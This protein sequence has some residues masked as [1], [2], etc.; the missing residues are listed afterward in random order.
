MED[1]TG[2]LVRSAVRGDETALVTLLEDICV[3]LHVELEASI[4]SRY[5][6]LVSAD[7]VL[8]VTCLEAFLRIRSFEPRNNSSFAAWIRRISEN[9]LKDAIRELERE[10]RPSP[11]RRVTTPAGEESYALLIEQLEGKATT[12]GR[13]VARKELRQVVDDALRKLPSDYE[14]VLRLYELEGL[15]APEVAERMN[16][17]HGAIRMMLS[18][19]RECLGELLGNES[20]YL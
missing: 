7:D 8:Q 16:R 18:R 2:D 6:G 15:S 1:R 4:G 13:A 3:S 5:R 20:K 17:S 12:V 9:N 10:K 14:R 11:S 19:A